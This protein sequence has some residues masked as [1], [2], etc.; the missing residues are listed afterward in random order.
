MERETDY[1]FALVDFAVYDGWDGHLHM[2]K[3]A[4]KLSDCSWKRYNGSLGEFP[5][6]DDLDC[7][8]GVVIP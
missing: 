2:W 8:Q 5:N 6:Q 1:F 3:N 7:L 4:L